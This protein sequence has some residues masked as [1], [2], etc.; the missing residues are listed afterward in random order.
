[1]KLIQHGLLFP[2]LVNK[3]GLTMD[4]GIAQNY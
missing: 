2:V 1:M 4:L 3:L